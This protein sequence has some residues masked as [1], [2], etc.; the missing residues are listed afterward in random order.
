MRSTWVKM[1]LKTDGRCPRKQKERCHRGGGHVK[2]EAE[3]GGTE[4]H[5]EEGLGTSRSWRRPGRPP[6]PQAFGPAD[7]LILDFWLLEL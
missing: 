6:P 4:S 3:A 7:T 5:A 2:A 1:A